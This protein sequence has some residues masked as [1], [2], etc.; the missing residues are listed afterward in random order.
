[1]VRIGKIGPTQSRV[2]FNSHILRIAEGTEPR[3]VISANSTD[4]ELRAVEAGDQEGLG[5]IQLAVKSSVQQSINESE[6]LAE[7]WKRLN[8][9][10]TP[11]L[12]S[13]FKSGR[14]GVSIL[15]FPCFLCIFYLELQGHVLLQQMLLN[16]RMI[17]LTRSYWRVEFP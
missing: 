15:I 6:T 5:L 14:Q 16:T 12:T 3:P 7:N 4:A 2:F 17:G 9:A 8:M 10:H 1:M 11:A 13:E